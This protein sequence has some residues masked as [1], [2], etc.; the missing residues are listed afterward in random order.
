VHGELK[1]KKKQIPKNRNTTCL[2]IANS[3]LNVT[4]R[5][6]LDSLRVPIL[7]LTKPNYATK[8]PAI[9]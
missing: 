5:R 1:N 9:G 3:G 6:R 2:N 4:P 8:N 7:E